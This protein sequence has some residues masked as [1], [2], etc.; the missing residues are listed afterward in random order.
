MGWIRKDNKRK[1]FFF[2]ILGCVFCICF[3]VRKKKEKRRGNVRV[4]VRARERKNKRSSHS[5]I[6]S[7]FLIVQ[8]KKKVKQNIL[9][10]LLCSFIE[11]SAAITIHEH[12][13]D[14][15]MRT[16][17]HTRIHTLSNNK[18]KKKHIQR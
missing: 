16:Y 2:D 10:S 6:F 13:S 12:T 18:R 17:A 11:R 9:F 7:P 8:T 4:D 3:S 14:I 1:A 15:R 5:P